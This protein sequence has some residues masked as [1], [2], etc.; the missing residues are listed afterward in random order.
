[1]D[2]TGKTSATNFGLL[3][4]R[5]GAGALLMTHG[6]QK[7]QM[8][9]DGNLQFADP[10]GLGPMVSLYIATGAEF[11]CAALV[12][13]GLLTR[14]AALLVA[15]NMAVAAVIVHAGDAWPKPEMA[16]LYGLVLFGLV[17]TGAGRFSVDGLVTGGREYSGWSSRR[18]GP[19]PA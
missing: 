5:A 3:V 2:E 14:L 17:F 9:M 15:V 6:I 18:A 12:V 16:V 19:Q 7:L 1:M 11:F 10:L 4:V 13:L 8:I